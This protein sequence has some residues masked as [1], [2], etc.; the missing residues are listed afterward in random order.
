MP[1]HAVESIPELPAQYPE[2]S[3][4]KELPAWGIYIRHASG[5]ELYNIKMKTEKSDFRVPVVLDDVKK[6]KFH[7]LKLNDK[8]K[9][10]DIFQNKTSEIELK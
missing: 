10:Q 1:L 8:F 4:F 3:M 7:N 6:S 2:F 9:P 5:I